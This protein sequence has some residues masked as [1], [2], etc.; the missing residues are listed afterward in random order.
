MAKMVFTNK[1]VKEIFENGK[2]NFEQFV[3]LA[4]N[5]GLGRKIFN[6]EGKEVD[7]KDVNS[8]LRKKFYEVLGVEEGTKGKELRRAF[9]RHIIDVFEITEDVLANLVITGWGANP[10]FDAPA[11]PPAQGLA[12]PHAG[13]RVE[14]S[15]TL[16]SRRGLREAESPS[17][18][19]EV[20]CHCSRTELE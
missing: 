10:F 4:T 17:G 15:L 3:E 11:H 2:L 1:N 8:E 16:L 9:R 18:D 13:H 12:E 6:S 20:E 5:A 7:A 19:K 14:N